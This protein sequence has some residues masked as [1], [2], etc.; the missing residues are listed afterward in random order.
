M[1]MLSCQECNYPGLRSR[2]LRRQM[3]FLLIKR[4]TTLNVRRYL[5]GAVRNKHN[6]WKWNRAPWWAD[7]SSAS[8]PK[9]RFHLMVHFLKASWSSWQHLHM[10]L[11]NSYIFNV[12]LLLEQNQRLRFLIL[13]CNPMPGHCKGMTGLTNHIKKMHFLFMKEYLVSR[14]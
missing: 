12:S 2:V 10:V 13:S 3:R 8:P 14:M 11:K 4:R 9:Q 1:S 5:D 7:A 6:T